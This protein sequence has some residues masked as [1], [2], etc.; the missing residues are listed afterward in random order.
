MDK[1]LIKHNFSRNAGVYDDYAAVQR[2]CAQQLIELLEGDSFSNILEI[3]CG[4]GFYTRALRGTNKEAQIDAVDIS[5]EMIKV[6]HRKGKDS[7]TQFMVFDGEEI[8]R[9][10]KFDLITSN[11]TFQWFE[12]LDRSLAGLKEAIT[13]EG[14]L[15][16]SMYGP[17]TFNELG[18][19]LSDHF[20]RYLPLT[21][22][23]FLAFETVKKIVK[24]HFS[25]VKIEEKHFTAD[26][27]SLLDFLRDIKHSGT[28][29]EGLA[30]DIFLG[31]YAIKE[32]EKAYIEKFKGIRATHHIYFCRAE[33]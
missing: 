9:E 11:A 33:K 27:I 10:K 5:E 8:S 6:A 4:T 21:S 17:E 22:K 1:R 14:S 24:R 3:G 30:R 18:E 26:F 7:T 29:G 20:G 19:V 25:K 32:I 16:F 31:Q 23:S 12:D 15:C 2:K 28:R 13:D